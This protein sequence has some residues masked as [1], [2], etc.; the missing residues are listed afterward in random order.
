[1]LRRSRSVCLEVGL[2]AIKQEEFLEVDEEVSTLLVQDMTR[3]KEFLFFAGGDTDACQGLS[4]FQKVIR[5]I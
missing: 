1:M 5:F 2:L 4:D 3:L